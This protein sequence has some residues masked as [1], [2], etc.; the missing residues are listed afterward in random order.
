MEKHQK[1]G[2]NRIHVEETDFAEI[3]RKDHA[4][5]WSVNNSGIKETD[6]KVYS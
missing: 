5:F 2:E 6:I 3:L 1:K 4:A